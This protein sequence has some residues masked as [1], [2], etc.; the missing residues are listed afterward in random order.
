MEYSVILEVY[1]SEQQAT[2]GNTQQKNQRTK[3]EETTN[4]QQSIKN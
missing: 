2:T 1:R 3:F 4:E